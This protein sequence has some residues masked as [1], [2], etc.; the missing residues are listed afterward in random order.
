MDFAWLLAA[1][2]RRWIIL[3]ICLVGGGA[4]GHYIAASQQKI[5]EAT[6]TSFVTLPTNNGDLGSVLSAQNLSGNYVNT[7]ASIASS[8]PVATKVVDSLNL[9]DSPQSVSGSLSAA[10]IPGTYLIQITARRADPLQASQIADAA[11]LG[12][13]QVVESLETDRSVKVEAKLVQLAAVPSVP[14]SPRPTF[15]LVV[16]LLLGLVVG[17][18][19]IALLQALDRSMR[20]AAEAEAAYGAP[21]LAIVPERSSRK[22]IVFGPK[23]STTAGEPY[24]SL[25]TSLRFVDPDRPM[26]TLLVTSATPEDG[27]STTAANLAIALSLA[28]DRV[29]LVDADLRRAGLAPMLQLERAAGLTSVILGQAALADVLQTYGRDMRVLETGPLPPNPS[30]ILGS[31]LFNGMLNQLAA[32]ADFVII[33]APPVLPVADAMT[34]ASQVDGVLMVARHGRTERNAATEAHRRL[35]AVGARIVG[36][37]FNAVPKLQTRH[38][39]ADYNYSEAPRDAARRLTRAV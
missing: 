36:V 25:R 39:Y 27:K 15:D 38:Q 14:I 7:F 16:G 35:T 21:V 10:A 19:G 28:G 22:P 17:L 3:L 1:V 6:A 33:D 12:L 32:T 34:L 13:Q 8:V 9:S 23:R 37:V 29:V 4:A 24:R 26:R 31:Q 5:Y 11:A 30:E 2:R 18:G 20:A